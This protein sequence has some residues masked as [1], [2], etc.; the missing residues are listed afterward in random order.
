MTEEQ[1]DGA[2][3]SS[4]ERAL[5]AGTPLH[6]GWIKFFVEDQRW[7]WSDEVARL[8][9]YQPGEVVPTTE[10]LLRYKHP[11]DRAQMAVTLDRVRHASRP[12]SSRHRIIDVAGRIHHVV[13]VGD[14]M[15]G[16]DGEVV[17]T[18]GNYVDVTPI[19]I[20][21]KTIGEDLEKIVEDRAVIEQAKGMIMAIYHVGVDTAF[22]LLQWRSQETNVK[23]RSLAAQ[24]VA[25]FSEMTFDEKRPQRT[26]YDRLLMTAHTR[27]TAVGNSAPMATPPNCRPR[28]GV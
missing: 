16:P 12:F 26:E 19:A 2:G 18:Q 9:G 13:V 14:R 10:L 21:H 7:E 22:K 4:A 5:T 17:G 11:D 28:G 15:Y 6:V 25:D 23:L 27:I 1:L 8:H 20:D 3:P 24:I